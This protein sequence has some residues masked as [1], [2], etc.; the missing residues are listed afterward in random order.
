MF[1]SGVCLRKTRSFRE[2]CLRQP[3]SPVFPNL[4][5]QPQS[6]LV[7]IPGCGLI[8]LFCLWADDQCSNVT[9]AMGRI[10]GIRLIE[11]NDRPTPA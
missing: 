9:S 11:N 1:S 4:K 5:N 2:N 10:M 7:L 6:A 3:E 8:T